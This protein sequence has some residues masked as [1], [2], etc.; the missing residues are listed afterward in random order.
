MTFSFRRRNHRHCRLLHGLSLDLSPH[1]MR[2]L[3]LPPRSEPPRLPVPP[4]W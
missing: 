1:L 4:F 2:D 3:G